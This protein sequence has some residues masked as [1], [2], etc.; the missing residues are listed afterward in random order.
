MALPQHGNDRPEGSAKPRDFSV[1]FASP[2]RF[3]N[4]STLTRVHHDGDAE[5][6]VHHLRFEDRAAPL[7]RLRWRGPRGADRPDASLGASGW[8]RGGAAGRIRLHRPP[9]QHADDGHGEGRRR[10]RRGGVCF[11]GRVGGRVGPQTLG[12]PHENGRA[13]RPLLGVLF[14]DGLGFLGGPGLVIADVRRSRAL[15]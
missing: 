6:N 2:A 3:L 9:D 14:G 15:S 13:F 5:L 11:T 12:P 7:R 10:P 1:P 4:R 8:R